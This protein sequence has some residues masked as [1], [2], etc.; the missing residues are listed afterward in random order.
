MSY[1]TCLSSQVGDSAL[2]RAAWGGET[3]VVAELVKGGAHLNLQNEVCATS[4]DFL[5]CFHVE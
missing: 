3:E 1:Y 2:M 4:T 5:C